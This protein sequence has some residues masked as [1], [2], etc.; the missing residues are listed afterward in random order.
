MRGG[1]QSRQ[2]HRLGVQ[3]W[4]ARA[5]LGAL[6]DAIESAS[7]P[8]IELHIVHRR[9]EFRHH[10]YI[11]PLARGIV[12]FGVLGYQLAINGLYQMSHQ[13]R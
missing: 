2:L 5:H 10:S 9:E 8:L 3:P 7:V 13:E 6:H 1:G 11:S 4:S 12:G